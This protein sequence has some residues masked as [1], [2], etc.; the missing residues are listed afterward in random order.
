MS[1]TPA[2][3]WSLN[4]QVLV[5]FLIRVPR[6]LLVVVATAIYL[7]L[8]IVGS[9]A[10]VATL[11]SFTGILSYWSSIFVPIL[12]IEHL[13][14]RRRNFDQYRPEDF[15]SPG[16]VSPGIA[17][18]AACLTAAGIIVLGMD[19]VW[20]RG[21]IAVGITGDSTIEYGGDLGFELGLGVTTLVYAPLRLLEYR[22][23]KR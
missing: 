18:L 3:S 11:N 10:Y 14:I 9:S 23:F 17:A 19:Q 2:D 15:D 12:I 4:A 8:A 21:P 1:L 5:P 13:L 20:W 6:F 22:F 7:P 16:R